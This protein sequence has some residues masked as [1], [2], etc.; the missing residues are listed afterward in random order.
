MLFKLEYTPTPIYVNTPHPVVGPRKWDNAAWKEASGIS[1][2]LLPQA[3]EMEPD[4]PDVHPIGEI[5]R[6]L[7]RMVWHWRHII[8]P[9]ELVKICPGIPGTR[10]GHPAENPMQYGRNLDAAID[11]DP[12]YGEAIWPRR[13]FNQARRIRTSLEDLR[14]CQAT[15]SRFTLG[16]LL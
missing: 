5:Q 2:E 15:C 14:G 1:I 13:I 16:P 12:N 9:I 3:L 4:A 6:Q 11:R 8:A 10:P 7:A